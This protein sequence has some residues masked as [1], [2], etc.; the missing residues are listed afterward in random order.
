MRKNERMSGEQFTAML[1]DKCGELYEP[2][3]RHICKYKNSYPIY[4]SSEMVKETLKSKTPYDKIAEILV[5]WGYQNYFSTF[6]V[7]IKIDGD[8]L[9]E[10]AFSKNAEIVWENDWWEGERNVELL[11]FAP[12]EKIKIENNVNKIIEGGENERPENICKDH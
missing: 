11:G 10:I 1:C 12:I 7:K 6:I 5:E 3:R 4:S 8:V 2:D 9:N